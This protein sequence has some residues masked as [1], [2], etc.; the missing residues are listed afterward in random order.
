M[1]STYPPPE[2]S[3]CARHT[4]VRR[5]DEEHKPTSHVA[6]AGDTAS[7]TDHEVGSLHQWNVR[8]TFSLRAGNQLMKF[9]PRSA[10]NWLHFESGRSFRCRLIFFRLSVI[11]QQ[12]GV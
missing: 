9:G 3:R 11:D 4:I 2:L 7:N 1:A 8:D 6:G 10:S 12:S 5:P